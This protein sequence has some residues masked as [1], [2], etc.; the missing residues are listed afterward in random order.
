MTLE[1][2]YF[3]GQTVAAVAVVLSLVFVG[4]QIKEHNREARLAA[5]HEAAKEYRS[6]TDMALNNPV[7]VELFIRAAKTGMDGM[8]EVE[9]QQMALL[10]H[11]NLRVY[12]DMYFQDKE[13][14]LDTRLWRSMERQLAGFST[15]VGF[16][17]YW[18]IRAHIYTDEFQNYV[19]DL[20][21]QSFSGLLQQTLNEKTK[22]AGRS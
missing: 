8:S 6:I 15:T 20:D 14:Q 7:L 1:T 5:M 16:K 3:V 4:F 10:Y 9:A 18:E 19:N 2:V 17:Q 12:E 11:S 21:G 13:G 22:E